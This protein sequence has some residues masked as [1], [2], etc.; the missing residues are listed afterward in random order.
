[1]NS[2]MKYRTI[3]AATLLLLTTVK[4]WGGVRYE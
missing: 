3:I 2:S 4:I 1:M